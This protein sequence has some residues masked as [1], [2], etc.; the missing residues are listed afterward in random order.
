MACW[1]FL[2]RQWLVTDWESISY[3]PQGLPPF[4]FS[5]DLH[6]ESSVLLRPNNDNIIGAM[7]QVYLASCRLVIYITI[8]TRQKDWRRPTAHRMALTLHLIPNTSPTSADAHRFLSVLQR[9]SRRAWG[10]WSS[11]HF[12]QSFLFWYNEYYIS[13]WL[14]YIK[15]CIAVA[16]YNSDASNANCNPLLV[17]V[18]NTDMQ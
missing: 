16:I 13:G 14:Y 17:S 18:I 7:S 9:D 1:I 3:K 10:F 4:K 6:E 8:A 2:F 12:I 11:S 5:N 15:M